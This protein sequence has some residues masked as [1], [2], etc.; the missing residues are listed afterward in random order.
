MPAPPQSGGIVGLQSRQETG[1]RSTD[2]PQ[3]RR[4]DT[5]PPTPIRLPLTDPHSNLLCQLFLFCRPNMR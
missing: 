3:R 5:S 1:A 2:T 4:A